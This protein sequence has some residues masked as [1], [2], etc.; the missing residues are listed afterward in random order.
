MIPLNFNIHT[1]RDLTNFFSKFLDSKF[2]YQIQI[3]SLMVSDLLFSLTSKKRI[4]L[5]LDLLCLIKDKKKTKLN[6]YS[7]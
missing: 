1:K 2:I 5:Y 4:L 3:K 6:L 7:K